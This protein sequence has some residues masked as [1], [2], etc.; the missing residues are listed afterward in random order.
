MEFSTHSM[1]EMSEES[2]IAFL[3]KMQRFNF[4]VMT[5]NKKIREF[6]EVCLSTHV[7]AISLFGTSIARLVLAREVH[8][9][10]GQMKLIM[11]G[12]MAEKIRYFDPN[13]Q[14]VNTINNQYLIGLTHNLEKVKQDLTH[15]DYYISRLE[16]IGGDQGRAAIDEGLNN[17]F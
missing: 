3:R 15:V 13:D 11:E 2:F 16:L 10:L 5:R 7:G 6:A 4:T 14:Y 17:Y 12:F 1:G 9:R 8:K